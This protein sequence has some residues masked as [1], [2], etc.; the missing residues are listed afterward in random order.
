MSNRN[1]V[2]AQ[3]V[4]NT[5]P[6][7]G[8]PFEVDE[9]WSE[10]PDL[11]SPIWGGEGIFVG[12]LLEVKRG[13][14]VRDSFRAGERRLSDLLLFEA[15]VPCMTADGVRI[16]A[17]ERCGVWCG[18]QLKAVAELPIGSTVR[19]KKLGMVDIGDRKKMQVWDMK[20]KPPVVK[21]TTH[22]PADQIPRD[23]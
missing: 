13:V 20:H 8:Q 2:N 15:V 7:A 3:S 1:G 12:V 10:V 6:P 19:L 18:A 14:S 9:G 23:L 21:A 16:E 11:L 5:T 17:G 4:P 22:D